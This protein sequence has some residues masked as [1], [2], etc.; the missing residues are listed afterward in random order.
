MIPVETIKIK[1]QAIGA[2]AGRLAV[3]VT[4]G[5]GDEMTP[6]KLCESI[7]RLSS[8]G[9]LRTMAENYVVF[10]GN[11]SEHIHELE[12]VGQFLEMFQGYHIGWVFDGSVWPGSVILERPEDRVILDIPKGCRD[13]ADEWDTLDPMRLKDFAIS[14]DG[15]DLQGAWYSISIV[16]RARVFLRGGRETEYD[17][18]RWGLG[19]N[20]T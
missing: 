13:V 17:A 3:H 18:R 11:T 15:E 14:L 10:T 7:N 6:E 20:R 2:Y 16:R 19:Y 1:H 12:S 9:T 4:V 5:R 8:D